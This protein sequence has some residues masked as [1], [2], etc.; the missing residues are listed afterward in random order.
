MGDK[1][2]AYQSGHGYVGFGEVTQR[3]TMIRD[4][5]VKESGVQLLKAGL[6]AQ[7]ANENSD[8]EELSEWV[9]GV[10][11]FKTVP[12]NKAKTF[13][14]VFANQNI[15][16]KLRHEQTLRFVQKEFGQ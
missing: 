14:G 12:I 2:Y 16:C 8:N 7:N 11:W 9:V 3:A 4:F 15:V 1:I 5:I 10:K 13:S 6:K